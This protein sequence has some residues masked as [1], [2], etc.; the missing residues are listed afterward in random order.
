MWS[1][2]R[3]SAGVTLSL[4]QG[5]ADGGRARSHAG[6]SQT[7]TRWHCVVQRSE[8]ATWALWS[9]PARLRGRLSVALQQSHSVCGAK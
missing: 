1:G 9:N 2:L 3:W 4:H 5:S 8:N 6:A 7:W